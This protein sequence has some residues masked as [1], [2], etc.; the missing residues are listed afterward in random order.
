MEDGIPVEC[1]F[2]KSSVCCCYQVLPDSQPLTPISTSTPDHPR[3]PQSVRSLDSEPMIPPPPV[4]PV[5]SSV[6]SG[7][8]SGRKRKMDRG[9]GSRNVG[10]VTATTIDESIS[11]AAALHM[12]AG[13]PTTSSRGHG[14][15]TSSHTSNSHS[16]PCANK[17]QIIVQNEM[18]ESP[19]SNSVNSATTSSSGQ[20]QGINGNS[21]HE[22]GASPH[23]NSGNDPDNAVETARW[24]KTGG[25]HSQA[26]DASV[27]TFFKKEDI[28]TT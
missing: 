26:W 10:S 18:M 24:R 9:G 14:G 7:K 27:S 5:A 22:S 23:T 12:D 20:G 21:G 16:S 6:V 25:S 4:A 3:T 11:A 17:R 13:N 28:A 1:S 8:S 19:V 15:T 2:S